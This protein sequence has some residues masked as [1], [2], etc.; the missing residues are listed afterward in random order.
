MI[1]IL[2]ITKNPLTHM[3]MIAG[4]CYGQ[5]NPKRFRKIA[6]RCLSEGHGRVSEFANVTIEIDGYSAKVIRELYTHIIGTNRV[7]SS[8]RYIDYSSGGFEYTVPESV[9]KDLHSRMIWDNVMNTIQASMNQLKEK[10]VPVEDFTNLLPLAYT[11]KMVLNINIRALVHMFNVR[12]CTCAYWE[13]RDLMKELKSVLS[14]QDDEW[15]Y[16][17]D[18]YFVPKCVAIGF[19]DESTRHCGI[20]PLKK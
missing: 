13:Y 19:C 16:I 11:T 10:G 12:A 17:S 5:D 4:I 8:T 9:S 18:N 1:K 6:E 15:K 14:Q 20:R 3:G 2:D 7:Q